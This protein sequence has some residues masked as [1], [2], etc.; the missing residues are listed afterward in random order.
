MGQKVCTGYIPVYVGSMYSGTV[1]SHG[2]YRFVLSTYRYELG[3]YNR[4][5]FQMESDVIDSGPSPDADRDSES[6]PAA[7]LDSRDG[8]CA[9]AGPR[10]RPGG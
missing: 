8:Q 6:D 5:R 9:A 4:S 1:L 7:R 2:T 3:T 10:G